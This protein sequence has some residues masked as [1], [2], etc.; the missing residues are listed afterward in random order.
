MHQA[1][2]DREA[3]AGAAARVGAGIVVSPEALE[4]P[5][6]STGSEPVALVLD[7]D[8]G[9][10][11]I[12]LD[13]DCNRPVRRRVADRVRQQVHQHPLKLLGSRGDDRV[14]VDPRLDVP[15]KRL[16]AAVDELA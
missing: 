12:R 4:H 7:R 8:D 11:G 2:R 9:V 5:G 1:L 13:D 10:I 14:R 3:E 16:D 15:A 6:G